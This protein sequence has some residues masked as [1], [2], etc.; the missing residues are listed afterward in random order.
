VDQ[1]WHV[2]LLT[3]RIFSFAK[4]PL[5]AL[6]FPYYLAIQNGADILYMPEKKRVHR[7][8]LGA[9]KLPALDDAY[10]GTPEDYMIYA[11]Y[12][13]GDFC[14]FRKGRISDQFRAYLKKLE[15]LADAPWQPM[16]EFSFSKEE[17]FPLIKC[18]G[19]PAAMEALTPKIRD[20]EGLAVSCIRDPIDRA[21]SLNLI[22]H[23]G[24]N[25][26]GAVR[27]LKEQLAPCYTIAA[28]DDRNDIPMLEE[29]DFAIAMEGAPQDVID[30]ADLIARPAKE[31]GIIAA[32]KEAINHASS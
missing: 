20:I 19:S 18:A 15:A 2:A 12:E 23:E 28:G 11:G 16:D 9:D 3:G 30:A 32:L 1:G 29:V 13:K 25:K 26:G 7:R 6:D 22:T 21:L 24:A 5:E 27:W 17:A 8:Y 31:L 4:G 10:A 14:Y